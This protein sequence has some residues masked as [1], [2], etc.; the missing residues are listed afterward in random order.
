MT[1]PLAADDLEHVVAH[2]EAALRVLK[3]GRIFITGGTGFFGRWLIESLIHANRRLGLAAKAVVLTRSPRQVEARLP[4][5]V[6]PSVVLH[7]GD[8]ADFTFPEGEFPFVLHA[9]TETVRTPQDPV[10]LFERN[11]AG[12]RRVLAFAGAAHAERFLFTS[13]G[14]VYGRQPVGLTHVPEEYADAAAANHDASA[15]GRSKRAS[16][17][18]IRTYCSR[19]GIACVIARCFAFVGPGLPL[20]QGYAVGNFV[21]DA[22]GGGPIRVNGDGTSRRSYLY[23]ADLAAWLWTLL[24]RGQRDGV[25]NVGSDAD[26]SIVEL[27][28]LVATE[29]DSGA[30]VEIAGSPIPGAPASRY[31]PRVDRAAADLGLTAWIA[32]PDAIRRMARWHRQE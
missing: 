27:A 20:D 24:A 29:V 18:L 6:D 12:T 21:R 15:Y 30:A 17:S 16:E 7:E 3:G 28:R 5:L 11:V 14:A 10:D 25:Y 23:A 9:A 1:K 2:S 8:M 32:L 19:H 4:H 26:L 13:S 22:L 31:V